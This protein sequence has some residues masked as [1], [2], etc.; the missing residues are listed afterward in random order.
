MA[1]S[2]RPT[3]SGLRLAD[4]AVPR[5]K[6]LYTVSLIVSLLVWAGLA[7]AL[8]VAPAAAAG[9]AMYAGIFVLA[10]L[11]L[12][13]L[14]IG[15]VRANGIR[16][17][18]RQF[19]ELHR[20]ATEHARRLG[21]KDV[22]DVFVIQGGGTL[23]AF[24][25]KFFS[26]RFVVLYSDVLELAY[27]QGEAAVGFVVAHELGHHHRGHV[28][29]RWLLFPSRVVPYLGAAYSRA[30][31]FT[32][33]RYGAFCQ[34]DGAFHGLLVLAAGKALHRRVNLQEYMRQAETET[35]YWVKRAEKMAT[36]PPLPKRL[37][38]LAKA[39][40]PLPAPEPVAAPAV[41]PV[42]SY[43][44]MRPDAGVAATN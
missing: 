7:S 12:H 20:L 25:T 2:A 27:E 33:D 19:P 3:S 31:E 23:N 1:A 40:V 39:G 30:C 26:R 13:G 6:A 9:V 24:A 34:P 21:M 15:N 37:A 16:V 18:P 36:H 17:G 11:M 44:P 10:G 28:S 22:P 14:M 4:L 29:W 41:L 38:A 43:S 32:C 5:E 42:P 8:V 35:G